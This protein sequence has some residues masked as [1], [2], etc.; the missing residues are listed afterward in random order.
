MKKK[1]SISLALGYALFISLFALDSIGN[2]LGFLIHLIPTIIV[3]LL[4]AISTKNSKLGGV[5]FTYFFNTYDN[6]FSLLF[7]SLPL[8]VI[9]ILLYLDEKKF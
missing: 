8:L 2:I 6:I 5:L 7:I 4:I 3:I 9:G 1:I